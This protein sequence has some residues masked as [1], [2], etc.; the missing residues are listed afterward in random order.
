MLLVAE[1]LEEEVVLDAEAMSCP[2]YE[3]EQADHK[4]TLSEENKKNRELRRRESNV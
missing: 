1:R 4:G 3:S 2:D